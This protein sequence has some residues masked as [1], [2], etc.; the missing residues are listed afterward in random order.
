MRSEEGGKFSGSI[1]V[2]FANAYVS[3][4]YKNREWR[5]FDDLGATIFCALFRAK[6]A[7]K[8]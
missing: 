4:G 8:T 1:H 2:S 3:K 6:R 5:K 7:Q